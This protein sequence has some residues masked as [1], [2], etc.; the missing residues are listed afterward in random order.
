MPATQTTHSIIIQEQNHD[1]I[2]SD[3][4]PNGSTDRLICS[5]SV[6]LTAYICLLSMIPD[7]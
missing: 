6:I 1:Y 7:F 4:D 5:N 2:N 3:K